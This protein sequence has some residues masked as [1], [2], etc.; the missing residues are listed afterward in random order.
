ML[1]R[2]KQNRKPRTPF[3]TGQLEI[4]EKKFVEKQYLTIPERSQ[5]AKNLQLTETQVTS[6]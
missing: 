3:S 5:F 1:R 4:M 6:C 2:H